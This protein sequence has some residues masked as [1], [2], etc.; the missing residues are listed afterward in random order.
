M[1]PGGFRGRIVPSAG[2]KKSQIQS[3]RPFKGV[4]KRRMEVRGEARGINVLDDF[5]SPSHGHP[6]DTNGTAAAVSRPSDLG[7]F[8]TPLNT[9]RRAIFQ[10]ELPDAL[11]LADGV[12]LSEVARLDQIPVEERLRP[13]VVIETIAVTG[14]RHFTKRMPTRSCIGWCHCCRNATSL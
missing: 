7:H 11:G 2:W 8:R 1:L 13:E 9:T 6:R 5:G 4:A 10:R 3:A 12:F 14:S